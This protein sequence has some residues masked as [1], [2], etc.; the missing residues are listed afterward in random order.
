MRW[1]CWYYFSSYLWPFKSIRPFSL[2]LEKFFCGRLVLCQEEF[3]HCISRCNAANYI[4]K[5]KQLY[6]FIGKKIILWCEISKGFHSYLLDIFFFSPLMP[7][8]F[9]P[10][11]HSRSNNIY[12]HTMDKNGDESHFEYIT[13]PYICDI[14]S[15]KGF[16]PLF[17]G[18]CKI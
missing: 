3:L 4:Q 15:K 6:L 17:K 11:H 18:V 13:N 16:F 1:G 10:I 14:G 9:Q 8:F 5:C 2:D 12:W 7:W